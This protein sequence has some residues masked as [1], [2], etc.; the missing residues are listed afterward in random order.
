MKLDYIRIDML[1]V[2]LSNIEHESETPLDYLKSAADAEYREDHQC[3]FVLRGSPTHSWIAI[4]Y[5]E[6]LD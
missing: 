1:K 5:G 6:L 2:V 3:W 4:K